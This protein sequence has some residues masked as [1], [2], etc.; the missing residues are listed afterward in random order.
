MLGVDRERAA[1][2]AEQRLIGAILGADWSAQAK[3]R[4][5]DAQFRGIDWTK[6]PMLAW[7][8]K[9]R[10]M[11]AAALR[12]AG[13]PVPAEVRATLEADE[14]ACSL[15][16][17]QQLKL[18]TA[19]TAAVG[20]RNI[21]AMAL[22]GAAL[23]LRLYGDPFIREAYDLDLLVHPADRARFE[24]LLR[25]LGCVPARDRP[26][27]SPR[28]Q[29]ILDRFHHETRFIHPG[30]DVVVE[31]HHAL[32]W[33]QHLIRTDF[34]ALW[35]RRS[36]V[37]VGTHTL[38][39]L[40]DDDLTYYVGMH[41]ACHGWERWK[42]I[43]DLAKL[44][45]SREPT[46]LPTLRERIAAEGNHHLFDSWLI[47]IAAVT[48]ARPP[49]FE[50]AVRNKTA[51]RL[52]ERALQLSSLPHTPQTVVGPAYYRRLMAYK[53][54]LKRSPKYLANELLA[55]LHRDEDWHAMRLPDRLIWLYYLA[56]PYLYLRRRLVPL[57][58]RH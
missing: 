39:T 54:G 5:D 10:P 46:E 11:V 43:A 24:D 6:L 12:E 21:R 8:H 47:L 33:N 17:M 45:A 51:R 3:R 42:W 16:S 55:M 57:V 58:R 52:A 34:E 18:L 25:G 19:I 7:Q 1:L 38:A 44:L 22:K 13:W 48:G 4:W 56:R 2:T 20:E 30:N 32:T 49:L 14:R 9:A 26:A 41:G 23:S 37:T 50:Q 28:Q 40:G 15:K 27:L 35:A 53:L 36:H 31:S 29:H